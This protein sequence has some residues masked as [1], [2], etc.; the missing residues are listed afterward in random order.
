MNFFIKLRSLFKNK[1]DY[2]NDMEE[3]TNFSDVISYYLPEF[4]PNY[5]LNIPIKDKYYITLMGTALGDYAGSD[6][7][8]VLIGL[9]FLFFFTYTININNLE[10]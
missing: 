10:K 3:T 5:N 6:M 9:F 8:I 1:F 2:T 4:I 7:E